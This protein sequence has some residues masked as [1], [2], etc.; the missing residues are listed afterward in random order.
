MGSISDKLQALGVHLGT[1]GLKPVTTQKVESSIPIESVVSGTDFRSSYG[2]CFIVEQTYDTGYLH[3]ITNLTVPTQ[4]QTLCNWAK[5]TN[6]TEL[7]DEKFIFLD[8]E[9]S[10]LAGGTGTFAFL[11]GLG[12]QKEGKFH[13]VQL[14]MR[15]PADEQALIAALTAYLDPF[16]TVITFNGKSFDIP[17]LK[18]RHVL[19]GFTSPFETMDHIDLLHLSRR[20]WRN[21]LTSRRLGSLEENILGFSRTGEEIPGWMVPEIYFEYLRSKDARP[22]KGVLYHNAIDIL[23]LA[24]LWQYINE[25]LNHP[26][27]TQNV[28]SVDLAAVA[29]LFDDLQDLDRAIEVY[30]LA[31]DQGL[32]IAQFFET[33]M[34]FGQLYRK[35]GDWAHAMA[36]WEKGASYQHAESCIEIAKF[37]E[38][39]QKVPETAL[40]WTQKAIEYVQKSRLPIYQEKGLLR[41]LEIRENRLIVKVKRLQRIEH[42]GGD[43]G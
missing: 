22:L 38:H 43:D 23:S 32:P 1:Q 24:G 20:L 26:H 19:N 5:T 15:D 3:G 35:K 29:K 11:V 2:D 42:K 8:T 13:L 37:Y 30:E 17:L 40:S 10:G 6:S 9:T 39:V 21:R 7:P 16:Q 36:V 4:H 27:S 31:I 18:T 33:I 12:Y 41:E 34:R 25:L 28:H 14:F